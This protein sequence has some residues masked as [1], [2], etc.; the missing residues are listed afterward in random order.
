MLTKRNASLSWKTLFKDAHLFTF[1]HDILMQIEEVRSITLKHCKL[2]FTQH[3][4]LEIEHETTCK[5]NLLDIQNDVVR[6]EI[7]RITTS[8]GAT[9]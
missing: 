1:I 8:S 2:R 7:E 3:Y 9:D 6:F 4:Y 5:F